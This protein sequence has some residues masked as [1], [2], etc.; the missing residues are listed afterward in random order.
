MPHEV[1]MTK[2]L[3]M[4]LQEWWAHEVDPQP[5]KS[6]ILQVGE[7]TCVEPRMLVK[8]FTQQRLS[9]PFLRD[10]DL[11][12]HNIPF[13]AHCRTCVRDYKPNLGLQY[14]CPNCNAPLDD[15]RSGR[16]LKIERI[17]WLQPYASSPEY[18]SPWRNDIG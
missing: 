6:V 18:N 12:I 13:I 1:D 5:V 10:A 11:L 4:S 17:E 14:A 8:S 9:V 3:I 15:I 7:F 2:A 16:E